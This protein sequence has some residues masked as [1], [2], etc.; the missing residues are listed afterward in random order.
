MSR[1]LKS[2][3]APPR[4]VLATGTYPVRLVHIIQ[5]GTVM[6]SWKNN[7]PKETP[8]IYLGFEFPNEPDPY[9]EE[10]GPLIK[11]IEFTNSMGKKA[12]LRATIE[13][14]IKV[15]FKDQEEANNFELLTL[16]NRTGLANI[17]HSP[18]AGDPSTIYANIESIVP[19]PKGM[20]CPEAITTLNSLVYADF[21]WDFYNSLPEFLQT[22]IKS[23]QEFGQ[24]ST[25]KP[26]AGNTDNTTAP[27]APSDDLPF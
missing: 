7:P 20:V 18:K 24:M 27:P 19:L 22:K 4:E 17:T 12:N 21:D 6:K 9:D 8:L 16:L 13:A 25:G 5:I 2:P 15:T 3:P 14:W 10:G 11:Y 1:S 23:S 26:F